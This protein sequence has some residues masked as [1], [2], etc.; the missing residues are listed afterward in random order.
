M[1][2]LTRSK[3]LRY[4]V[5]VAAALQALFLTQL[6]DPLLALESP[7][8]LLFVAVMVSAGYGGFGPGLLATAL[9]TLASGYLISPIA[10]PMTSVSWDQIVWLV[11][12][13]LL[14]L[15][16][17][18]L[19]AAHQKAESVLKARVCQQTA[20]VELG[21]RAL[22]SNELAELL[23]KAAALAA[24]TLE[25]EYCKILERLPGNN[26]L[27][28][29][30][31]VGWEPGVVGQTI[32][33]GQRDSHAGYTLLVNGPVVVEDLRTETRFDSP[34]LLF[35]HGVISSVSVIIQG[36]NQPFG[37]LSVCTTRRRHFTQDDIKFLEAIANVLAEAVVRLRA[38]TVLRQSEERF[39][40]LVEGVPDYA[41]FLMDL[42]G[43]IASWN[44][45]AERIL[46]YSEAEILGEYCSRFF[47]PEDTERG[48]PERELGTA[49]TTGR[50]EDDRWH[51]RKDGSRF[52]ASGVVTPLQE[53]SLQGFVKI[54]RDIT[55]RRQIEER[56]RLQNRAMEETVNGIVIAD[57]HAADYPL[58][59]YNPAFEQLTGYTKD[60]IL[61]RNCRFLQGPDTDPQ[62]RAQIRLALR[63]Q[64]HCQ[65]T[66]KNYR[67][68]GTPFWNELAIAPVR[69]EEGQLTHYI[70]VHTD[71]TERQQAEA[72]RELLLQAEQAARAKAEAANRVKDEF[73]AT[74]SHELRTPLNAMLGWVQL[75]R[76]RKLSPATTARALETIER[77]ARSQAQ[78]VEDLLDI[79]RVIRGKFY[80]NLRPCALV[81]VLE[82]VVE[83]VLPAAQSKGIALELVFRSSIGAVMGDPDRLQQVVWNL[84]A[85]AIKFTPRGGRV[86]VR[87]QEG[88]AW[89]QIQVSD[90]GEGISAEFLPYVF[91][92]FLQ[93]D[94]TST[95]SYG[96]LGLGL[97]IVRYL[98]E[99]HGGTVQAASPGEGQGATFTVYLPLMVSAKGQD[100][101]PGIA[102]LAGTPTRETPESLRSESSRHTH[103]GDSASQTL[104]GLRVLV[105][106]DEVDTLELLKLVFQQYGGQVILAQSAAEAIAAVARERPDVLV[107]D[108][109]MPGEDGYS[110]IQKVRALSS[111]QG[112]QTPAIALTAYARVEDCQRALA[113]GFQMHVAKPVNPDELVATVAKLA[114]CRTADL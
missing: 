74:L 35:E 11:I 88:E 56:L 37:V 93:A 45:G 25:V 4:G 7:F 53:G 94:S 46:G 100:S 83:T 99:L 62:V 20:V 57:A 33:G 64:R 54:M 105:V 102:S 107:S 111:A 85:N 90:T 29:R 106:D 97:A 75:L 81:P 50:S 70:G 28:L 71:V 30:A 13:I 104:A 19:A 1:L 65:V 108:I 26:T 23:S 67:K 98:V 27:L 103:P 40:L 42:D 44:A 22:R 5:A 15:L 113:A 10:R 2:V 73:L 89:A 18:V 68:D 61:G 101:G 92:R 110:L 84:L 36:Q 80:L 34:S 16:I 39:R 66:I 14:A 58:I 51:I 72:E 78:L 38:E 96:G 8:L 24:Q 95:R 6:L 91:E 63:E 48:A 31:G 79:S 76:T 12:Y 55:E 41:M 77:N 43:R 9:T 82:A 49:L 47:T 87:L 114:G 32:F 59:Y 52:W 3:L 86:E 112:G 109:S 17:S 21:Q 60:E 69:D